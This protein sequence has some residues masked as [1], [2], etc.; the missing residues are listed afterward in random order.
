MTGKITS[1]CHF[2]Q[3]TAAFFPSLQTCGVPWCLF[4]NSFSLWSLVKQEYWNNST[5]LYHGCKY[6][7]QSICLQ[8]QCPLPS[9]V[10]AVCGCQLA[11]TPCHV[12][13]KEETEAHSRASEPSNW[14]KGTHLSN[15]TTNGL[16]LCQ[17]K[18]SENLW[19]LLLHVISKYH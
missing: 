11:R 17:H 13:G 18:I 6:T 4:V 14:L 16:P 3:R 15:C 1:A 8:N 12:M 5:R 19:A 7:E 9:R 10:D 2:Y